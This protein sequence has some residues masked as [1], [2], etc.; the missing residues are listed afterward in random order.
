MNTGVNIPGYMFIG[1]IDMGIVVIHNTMR[2]I[3]RKYQVMFYS[4]RMDLPFQA[5]L[6]IFIFQEEILRPDLCIL[7]IPH[8]IN[9]NLGVINH[10][11]IGHIIHSCI[12]EPAQVVIDFLLV[13]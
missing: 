11:S 13:V 10:T 12:E 6:R 1:L 2:T 4:T 3:H 5:S 7:Q 9:R 8:I